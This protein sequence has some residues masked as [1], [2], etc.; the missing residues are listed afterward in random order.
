ME[1]EPLGQEAGEIESIIEKGREEL[2]DIM[3]SYGE[4]DEQEKQLRMF[5]KRLNVKLSK[6]SQEEKLGILKE[7]DEFLLELQ[8]LAPEKEQIVRLVEANKKTKKP[9]DKFRNV[10]MPDKDVEEA[11]R[12]R[13]ELV[14]DWEKWR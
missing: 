10:K 6:F 7:L 4:K 5:F 1:K 14:E 8:N 11:S 9:L 3:E 2:K 13:D 12:L